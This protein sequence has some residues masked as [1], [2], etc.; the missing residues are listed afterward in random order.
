MFTGCRSLTSLDLSNFDT[1]K[2]PNMYQMFSYCS[3]LESLDLS[4]WDTSLVTATSGWDDR[5]GSE[6]MFANCDNL[7]QSGITTEGATF[8]EVVQAKIDALPLT[9][10]T[11]MKATLDGTVLIVAPADDGMSLKAAIH[12]VVND[13]NR[14]KITEINIVPPSDGTMIIPETDLSA[15]FSDDGNGEEWKYYDLLKNIKG[16]AYINTSTVKDMSSMF[17]GCSVLESLDVSSFDTS[18]VT[19]MSC[20]FFSCEKLANIDVSNFNTSSVEATMNMFK[21]CYSL[22]E[23]ELLSWNVSNVRDM[24]GLFSYCSSLEKLDLSN[25]DTSNVTATSNWGSDGSADMFVN[26]DK[27]IKSGITTTG[28]SLGSPSNVQEKIEELPKTLVTE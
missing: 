18:K 8:S 19:N 17:W 20:M 16:L 13:D 12:S 23:L 1:S 26:C 5:D 9:G 3:S 28:A 11:K 6:N 21:R 14:A 22:K 7:I 27:L 15:L 4:N 24:Y 10:P 2:A 25:W